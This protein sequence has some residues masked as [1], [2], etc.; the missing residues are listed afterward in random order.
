MDDQEIVRVLKET[1]RHILGGSPSYE[2]EKMIKM[3]DKAIETTKK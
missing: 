2:F 3:L 1:R